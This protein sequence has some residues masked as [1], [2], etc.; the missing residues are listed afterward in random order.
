[1]RDV[2]R[3]LGAKLDD[4][5]LRP[6]QDYNDVRV[7]LQEPEVFAIHQADLIKRPGDYARDFLGRALP[8]CLLGPHVYIQAGRQ[9]RKMIDQMLASLESRDALVTIGPGPAPRFDAQRTFGFFHAFWG[10]PNLTSPFS[11]TGFP[12][13]NVYTG[14]TKLG[15]PLSMQ[16]AARPFEDAM[17]LR[18]G[19][20]YERATQ[21]RT[22]RPQL[23]QGAS[24]P[25]IE[26]AAEPPSPTLNSRM[27]TFIECSAE[28]AGLRLTGE[29]MELLFRAAPYALAMALRVCNGHDWSLEPAAA[30]RLEE[31]VCWSSP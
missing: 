2:L 6:L 23:V 7:L 13:L 22:R 11:V 30:F 17:V 5:T 25:A 15:L 27:Q 26:L 9:R 31:F 20:A 16:I 3:H 19:D 24:H 1:M 18:I 21:W 12:A 28:Q 10:K 29:Q 4:V 14:H 8:A